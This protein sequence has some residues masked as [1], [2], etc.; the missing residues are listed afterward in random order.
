MPD[1][2]EAGDLRLFGIRV[3]SFFVFLSASGVYYRIHACWKWLS[4]LIAQ[5]TCCL[6]LF[7]G[8][9][10]PPYGV[11]PLVLFINLRLQ[12]IDLTC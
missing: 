8:R 11:H 9:E 6:I 4:T 7:K 10:A 3:R 5:E 12:P 2:Q 1:L